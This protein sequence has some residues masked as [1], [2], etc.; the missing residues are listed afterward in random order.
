[1]KSLNAYISILHAN[2][3]LYA[4]IKKGLTSIYARKPLLIVVGG[5]G[6]EPVTSTV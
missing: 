1:M 6:F 3:C 5:T 4:T 2:H